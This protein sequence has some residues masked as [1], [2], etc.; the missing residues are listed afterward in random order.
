MIKIY[1][2]IDN[3]EIK[4]QIN[5]F[6]NDENYCLSENSGNSSDIIVQISNFMPDIILTDPY[7]KDCEYIIRQLKSSSTIYNTQ[8]VFLIENDNNIEFLNLADGLITLPLKE[9]VVKN[10]LNSHFKIK[11]S[12]LSTFDLAYTKFLLLP[13][14]ILPLI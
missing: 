1:T 8:I 12:L 14:F 11:Q 10:V 9:N 5:N 4:K 13:T 3:N 7:S 2:L 6:L